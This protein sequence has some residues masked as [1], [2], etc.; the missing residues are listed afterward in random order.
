MR[1][2]GSKNVGQF[3]D[4]VELSISDCGKGRSRR[5]VF[6]CMYE[7][8]CSLSGGIGRRGFGHGAVVWKKFDSLG[9]ALGSSC[10]DVNAVAP[11][12]FR[13]SADVP[14]V[15]T[16]WI[17]GAPVGRCFVD[18]DFDARRCKRG[19]I[20]VESAIELSVRRESGV[21]ARRSQ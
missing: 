6:E 12:M 1:S 10:G 13:G 7:I 9:D 17:P 16:M 18:K 3:A 21:D 2:V 11:I 8:E 20:V 5:R 4:G 15:D 19:A 14:A